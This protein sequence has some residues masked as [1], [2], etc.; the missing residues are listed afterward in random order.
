MHFLYSWTGFYLYYT[1]GKIT[2]L[3]AHPAME[4]IVLGIFS[5]SKKYKTYMNAEIPATTIFFIATM[6]CTLL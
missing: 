1:K 3:F 5:H 6:V 4:A 2:G